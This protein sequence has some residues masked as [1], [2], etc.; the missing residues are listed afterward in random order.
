M[1]YRVD[2][3][4]IDTDTHTHTDAGN[5]NTERPKLASGKNALQKLSQ[6]WGPLEWTADTSKTM[7]YLVYKAVWP[8]TQTFLLAQLMLKF[9]RDEWK[10]WL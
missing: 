5:D 7:G 10:V 2:K 3:L 4:V 1:S 6:P 9:S 8:P